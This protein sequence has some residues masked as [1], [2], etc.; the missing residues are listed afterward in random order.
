MRNYRILL[1]GFFICLAFQNDLKAT[2]VVG[3]ELTYEFLDQNGPVSAPFR[4]RIKMALYVDRNPPSNFPTGVVN[5]VQIGVYNSANN[6]RI[7]L[8]TLQPVTQNVDPP[9]PTGCNIPG[10]DSINVTL[11]TYDSV[12]NLPVSFSGYF[13]L[14]QVCCRNS[15]VLNVVNSLNEGNSF[16]AFIPPSIYRNTSPQFTDLAIPSL[17]TGDTITIVN[18][19]VDPDGDKLIY[20]FVHPFTDAGNFPPFNY[21]PPPPL[22][23]LN[24]AGG[25]SVLNPFGP[26]GFAEINAATGLSRYRAP[27]QGFYNVAI[28]I[29]EFRNVNGVDVLLSSTIREL[30]L[31]S[32]TCPPNPTP[33]YTDTLG[34]QSTVV[35][36]VK[37]GQPVS[38]TVSATDPDPMT[39]TASSNLL[40]GGLGYNGPLATM[41][42]VSGAGS[43]STTFNWNPGCN[44]P[45]TYTVNVKTQDL[46]C[47][48]KASN[49]TY[50]INVENFKAPDKIRKASKE[51]NNAADSICI[52][53]RNQTY[54]VNGTSGSSFQW[55]IS[56]G[57]ILSSSTNTVNVRWDSAAIAGTL[58][59]IETSTVGC[60]DS[61]QMI[62]RVFDFATVNLADT[63]VNLC[64]GSSITLN[65]TG[66]SGF[67]WTPSAGLSSTSIS[68]PV[69]N[70]TVTTMYRVNPLAVVPGCITGDSIR[71]NVIPTLKAAGTDKTICSGGSTVLGLDSVNGFTYRWFGPRP[72]SDST[73][74]KPIFTT[75]ATQRDSVDLFLR[76]TQVPVGCQLVDT[77][78]VFINPLPKATLQYTGG[79]VCQG[80]AASFNIQLTGRAPYTVVLDSNGVSQ[81]LSN[82]TGS[83]IPITRNYLTGGTFNYRV[84]SVSDANGCQDT[85]DSSPITITVNPTPV[86][87]VNRLTG[88]DIC[89]GDSISYQINLSGKSPWTIQID[90]NLVFKTFSNITN[91]PFI[92]SGIASQPGTYSFRLA[93]VL[94]QDNC[95]F[96]PFGPRDTVRVNPLPTANLVRTGGTGAICSGGLVNF[97]VSLT[98]TAPWSLTLDSAGTPIT[99]SGINSSPFVFSRPISPTGT[100]SYFVTRVT[101]GKGCINEANGSAINITVNPLPTAALQKLSPTA[102]FICVGDLVNYRLN[103]TGTSP[104]AVTLDSNGVTRVIS[105]IS[106]SVFDFSRLMGQ[107]SLVNLFVTE[108]I[109]GNG[110]V[111][112]ADQPVLQ[113]RVKELPTA[114]LSLDQPAVGYCLFDTAR[115]TIN[116]SGLSPWAVTLDS[117]GIGTVLNS[118]SP[119]VLLNKIWTSTGTFPFRLTQVVDSLC[120]RLNPD[121]IRTV[122]VRPLPTAVLSRVNVGNLCER[123]TGTFQVVLTGTAPWTVR[124]DSM[125]VPLTF[126]GITASP[127]IFSRRFQN[128][129]SYNFSVLSVTDGNN[130]RQGSGGPVINVLVNPYPTATLQRLNPGE[131]CAGDLVNYR[132]NLTGTANWTVNI[133][134]AGVLRSISGIGSSPLDFSRLMPIAGTFTFRVAN[135]LDQTGCL[136]TTAG[137]RDTVRV[138][139]LPTANMVRTGGSGAICSGASVIFS[140][141][142]TGTAPWSLSIDSA[143]TLIT[144]TG[145]SSSPFVFSRLITTAGTYSYFVTRVT[146]GK[147]CINEANGS[148]INITVNPL[149][150]AALQKLSPTANF[151]CVGDLVNYRLNLT[152]TSPWAVTLDS[153]GVTRVISAI[154]TSVFDF[155]RLMGQPSLVNLFVTEVIDGNGCVNVA[156]QPVLQFRVK[157]LPT[158]ALSLDQPAVGYCLFDTARFTINLSG[159]SPWAV[160]LDSSGI[161]TVLNSS[162]PLVLL[163]KIWTST[164]TFPF[165]L[166]QVVDSLCTRLNPDTIR[167]VVVRPLPTAVLSR[168]N[169]GNLCERDTGTF[170]VVLTGTAPWTVRIDSMGVPL[171]FSGITASP[172]IFSR[173]FQ[174][175]G[176]YN[177]SVLSV[178]DGNNCRQGSGGPVINVLVNPYPT[179]TLQR[180]NPGELCAGDLVNYRLNLTGTANWTVNI[181]SGGVLRSI[182][183]IGSS[184][185]DFSRL[186]P[187]AGTFTFRVANVLDQTG[188]LNTTAGPRDTVRVNPLPTAILTRTTGTGALCTN[189]SLSFTLNLT[190]T[191]PWTVE[192]DSAGQ[193]ITFSGI[194]ASPFVFFRTMTQPGGI[195]YFVTRVTDAKGCVN[196]ADGTPVPVLINPLPTTSLSKLSPTANLIC[197]GDSVT[198]SV[199]L[200]GTA[201]W[202]F[203][204]DSSSV[205]VQT[206][207][208][209]TTNPFVFKRKVANVGLASYRISQVTD[210][211]GCVNIPTQSPLT[212]TIKELP[213]AVLSYDAPPI[214]VC[215]FDTVQFSISLTGTP[216][217]S[218]VLDSAGFT[219]TINSTETNVVFNRAQ[220]V[221]GLYS[222][223]IIQLTD[224]LCVVSNPDVSRSFRVN[225]LP[226]VNAGANDS[227]CSGA[228]VTLGGPAQSGWSYVWNPGQSLNDSTV[229]SPVFSAVNLSGIPFTRTLIVKARI[230]ST[231]CE[232]RDTVSVVVNPNP[233]ANAGADQAICSGDTAIVGAGP[234]PRLI[235]AWSAP[236]VP[237][238][239]QLSS[240]YFTRIVAN[241]N[242]PTLV[243]LALQTT[244]T[245]SSCISKDTVVVTVNPRPDFS[246]GPDQTVCSGLPA[247]FNQPVLG[248]YLFTWLDSL[249]LSNTN[250]LNTSVVLQNNSLG[251]QLFSYRV[252]AVNQI[253]GC[254]NFDTVQLVIQPAARAQAGPDQSLCSGDTIVIGAPPT[255]GHVYRWNPSSPSAP[256]V[257]NR[258]TSITQLSLSTPFSPDTLIYILRANFNGCLGFDTLRIIVN[259]RPVT[260]VI[261]GGVSICPGATG[262]Q[263][264]VPFFAGNTYQWSVNGGSIVGGQGNDTLTVDWGGNN[265]TAGLTVQATNIYGCKSGFGSRAVLINPILLTQAPAGPDSLCFANAGTVTYSVVNTNGS[266]YNWQVSNGTILSPNGTNSITVSWAGV[267]ASSIWLTETAVFDTLCFGSSDTLLV[268]VLPEPTGTAPITGN[269]DPC[270][271]SS[272]QLYFTS[273]QSGSSFTWVLNNGSIVSGQGNDSI[274]INWPVGPIGPTQLSYQ[275]VS[276]FG[277]IGPVNDTSIT[278]RATPVP[279]LNSNFNVVCATGLDS[280]IYTVSGFAGSGFNWTLF[281]GNLINGQGNDTVLV[282][283]AATTLQRLQ[284]VETS[285]YGC[286]SQPDTLS[287][288]FDQSLPVLDYVSR[289]EN[290][291]SIIDIGYELIEP[292]NMIGNPVLERRVIGSGSTANWVN[293]G[294]ISKALTFRQDT[295]QS[296]KLIQEYRIISKNRCGKDVFSEVHNSIRLKVTKNEEQELSSLNW[297]PYIG[298]PEGVL[299]YEIWRK[300]D[301]QTGYSIY[302][303]TIAADTAYSRTNADDGF[304]HCYRIRVIRDLP[305]AAPSWSSFGCITFDHILS[306]SNVITANND[307]INDSWVVDNAQ[308]YPDVQ[309]QIMNRWGKIVYQSNGYKNDWSAQGLDGGTYFYSMKFR[310]TERSGYIQVLK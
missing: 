243:P 121:T 76:T 10:I 11:N 134:S 157:E 191:A 236:V 106:T 46:G 24:T 61:V 144:F 181:D 233:I 231:T 174:N 253:S 47:P 72:V 224:S 258:D 160:T 118:S 153:N 78:R 205:S 285:I 261:T 306:I 282:S 170:Q 16:I 142:L 8:L 114:A 38:F 220:F 290:S 192:I 171:T 133:D 201:P 298:W 283:W 112:V 67:S 165:R 158:A 135:V 216:N 190:G 130:C 93:F 70:P 96:S 52:T 80:S 23:P 291:T 209:I 94:D 73:V 266:S 242:L 296:D 263:Y 28:E 125:G 202:A 151:I 206:Y 269:M 1:L 303:E 270:E 187:I 255:I 294:V 101:D 87:T 161:G 221:T 287:L 227:I 237:S 143:G 168:V 36:N 240:P 274:R 21:T 147:G 212:F 146:D 29:K 136:N 2:H 302:D 37:E 184:P 74:A 131:L 234:F 77:V 186:M 305:S 288:L 123:D 145:I 139:P 259:P 219:R 40:T 197:S 203:T 56:G 156:D 20:S 194:T 89:Q 292:T 132:L 159:L 235:Y 244:D 271:L 119:L 13:L 163:N 169:V 223:R 55:K 257:F 293:A 300:L 9:L 99:I 120:T 252:R 218:L 225:I 182:S 86:T 241:G 18:N 199:S 137:P 31:I 304:R 307:G 267:G 281:N 180:L 75:T 276:F 50:L 251:F 247:L 226:P 60:Q 110:C 95:F 238:Q 58:K 51:I 148:A 256:G 88:V 105:A 207:T 279:D 127:F 265:P 64:I 141:A 83:T 15:G 34:N 68:N 217:W 41:P 62:G 98:G 49:R 204:L 65:A 82:L 228:N 273:G 108:V 200:T 63:G 128:P 90:S 222:F 262:V 284:V 81:V 154:S 129:G 277:C 299:K 250:S 196:P 126:S 295:G 97:S 210:N 309:V 5:N 162:S 115:F 39:I 173:R 246:L 27:L 198:F 111:N 48:P 195:S 245:V 264:T 103:L 32:K 122:V 92:F 35:I 188:C 85:V 22:I 33:V 280:L 30:Q 54:F 4:Y 107:P 3:G 91:S 69:A 178:T 239:N 124:I 45:G 104:W 84:L 100:Y 166:T 19:A 213:T 275:E 44:F 79:N 286:V 7:Q 113:F 249:G 193:I 214:G 102:N 109:D 172:F 117:S 17:C 71:V 183:G 26:G 248:P 297:N 189:D 254:T 175:P 301:N 232:N 185:L 116:L 155:S 138:N 14:W 167:T 164:G 53:N 12:I 140:V 215:L 25:Y 6:Q 59:L 211:N 57:T 149:P 260:P 289:N 278:I 43:I 179:A 42:S 272:G 268:Q 229:S 150:T 176:S 230:D 66:S 208:G 308:L 310:G 177:F 152:G